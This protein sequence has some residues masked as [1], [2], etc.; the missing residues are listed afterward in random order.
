M[1]QDKS[2]GH[3]KLFEKR[4]TNCNALLGKINLQQGIVELKCKC[5]TINTFSASVQNKASD[6]HRAAVSG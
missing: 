5:G 2:T 4:C 3:V 1:L 6:S